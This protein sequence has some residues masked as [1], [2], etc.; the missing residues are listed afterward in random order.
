MRVATGDRRRVEQILTNL[1]ANALKFTPEGGTVEIAGRVDGLAAV[2][3]V[4]DDGDGIPAED[5]GRIFERFQRLV[6]HERVMGTG[7]GLPI[8]RDL[9]RQM[10]GDLDVASVPGAGSAFVLV[11]P[12]PTETDAAD[13]QASLQRALEE[14]EVE[15]EERIVR[16]AIAAVGRDDEDADG[17]GRPGGKGRLRALP[18]LREERRAGA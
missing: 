15:L 13:L 17:A 12:G 1:V 8:A 2:L 6:G 4:S 18:S 16:R 5:R 3:I 7:L 10:G 14:E 11:L 9:A